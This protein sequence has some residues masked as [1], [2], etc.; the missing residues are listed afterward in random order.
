M[1]SLSARKNQPNNPYLQPEE[2]SSCPGLP[3]TIIVEAARRGKQ[4]QLYDK[5]ASPRIMFPEGLKGII[6]N[7]IMHLSLIHKLLKE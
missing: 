3:I 4:T 1:N 7:K 6:L 2:Y 5:V